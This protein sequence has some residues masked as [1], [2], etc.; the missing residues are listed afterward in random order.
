[1]YRG[2][3]GTDVLISLPK[4]NLYAPLCA[5]EGY[6][7]SCFAS[8]DLIDGEQQRHKKAGACRR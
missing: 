1:M 2:F 7:S 6:S 3:L 8:R 4:E 5:W